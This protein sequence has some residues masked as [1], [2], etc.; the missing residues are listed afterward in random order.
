MIWLV[1][2]G[3]QWFGLQTFD[4]GVVDEL[5]YRIFVYFN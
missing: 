3:A 1:A 4:F 5:A 2:G